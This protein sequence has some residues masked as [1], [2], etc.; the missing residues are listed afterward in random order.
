MAVAAEM[1]EQLDLAD[2]DVAFISDLIDSLIMKILPNWKP[3]S[4][5]CSGGERCTSVLTL[6]SDLCDM[7]KKDNKSNFNMDRQICSP[8]DG[9]NLNGKSN[10]VSPS[11][12]ACTRSPCLMNPGNKSSQ[13]S[14]TSE[15]MG[16][17]SSIKNGKIS[18]CSSGTVSEMDFRDLFY[19]DFQIHETGSGCVECGSMDQF[20]ESSEMISKV[21]SLAS[22]C[23]TFNLLERDPESDLKSEL[24][25]IEA[26]YQHCLQELSKMRQEVMETTKKKWMT[27]NKEVVVD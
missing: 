17:D 20:E 3:S 24:E 8:A 2:H 25:A 22:S 16:G 1:V 15:V 5:C 12:A 19:E 11:R 21:G 26:Q 18:K 4:G 14:E 6:T 7:L 23:S 13:G 9:N 27:K 10:S